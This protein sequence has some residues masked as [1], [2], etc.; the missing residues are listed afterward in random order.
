MNAKLIKDFDPSSVYTEIMS[1]IK[2][3]LEA[4]QNPTGILNQSQYL[5]L[6]ER[7]TSV[8]DRRQRENIYSLFEQYERRKR[9]GQK[10]SFEYDTAD[11]VLH[12][13]GQVQ[14]QG[15]LGQKMHFVY[16]DE[17][18]DFTQAQ[19]ALFKCICSNIEEGFMFA[20]DTAQTIARGVGFRF[21]DVRRL[22]YEEFLGERDEIQQPNR[23]SKK[24]P[25]VFQLS[26]NFRTHMGI[27]SI[28]NSVVQLLVHF[29]PHSVDK[30]DPEIS[31]LDGEAPV[32]IHTDENCDLLTS[33][34]NRGSRAGGGGCEFGAEQVILVR[35]LKAKDR[36]VIRL[37]HAGLVL[38]VHECKG[39]EFQVCEVKVIA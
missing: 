8:Y 18:Q 37:G 6:A 2:G 16:V 10:V 14:K 7:R 11:L 35:D 25:D 21:E 31:L 28:A 34:F 38:S 3:S 17:V 20:G 5:A 33:L 24:V 30:L 9:E 39:L 13:Y 29:F 32:F 15:F 12:L 27:V 22:Y 36:L 19:I 23:R 26:M 1:Q 4:L